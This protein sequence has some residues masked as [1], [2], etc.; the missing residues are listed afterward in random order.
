MLNR[1]S[2]Y[3]AYKNDNSHFHTELFPLDGFRCNFV[4]S[5]LPE[6]HLVYY[7]DTLQ[8]CRIGH[9]DV[10]LTRM[11]TLAF[12]LSE[13]FSLDKF[14]MQIRVCSTTCMTYFVSV[15]F[16]HVLGSVLSVS[17]VVTHPLG[18]ST[19]S[20]PDVSTGNWY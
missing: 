6:Y 18:L 9:D 15:E 1:S 13:L 11:T 3:V 14:P 17:C 12:I 10:L 2:R 5:P 16:S 20:G 7:H 4:S 8:L 19:G